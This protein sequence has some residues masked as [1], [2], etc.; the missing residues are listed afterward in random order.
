MS[1]LEKSMAKSFTTRHQNWLM[2]K[3]INHN[4]FKG[5][6]QPNIAKY[7]GRTG[8]PGSQPQIKFNKRCKYGNECY[9]N[10]CAIIH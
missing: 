5:N 4:D 10:K 7:A 2:R 3:K 1:M 6:Y 8:R 9:S